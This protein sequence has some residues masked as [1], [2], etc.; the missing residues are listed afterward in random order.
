MT[1]QRLAIVSAGS[2]AI[3]YAY[4]IIESYN[5]DVAINKL[6]LLGLGLAIGLFAIGVGPSNNK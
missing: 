6:H 5:N 4:M 1:R 3:L 2:L